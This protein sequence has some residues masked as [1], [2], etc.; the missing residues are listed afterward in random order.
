MA[1]REDLAANP[2]FA[3]GIV[4]FQHK[5]FTSFEQIQFRTTEANEAVAVLTMAG[6]EAVLGFDGIRR[7]FGLTP[8]TD[9][10]KML[11]VVEKGLKFVRGLKPGDPIPKEIL[12]GEASWT[13]SDRHLR[14]AHQRLTLQLVTWLTGDEHAFTSPEELLQVANDPQVKKNVTLAF[15]EAAE[16]LGIG[17]DRREEVV[18]YIEQLAKEFAYIEALRDVF[19]EIKKIDEKI[20]GLRRVYSSD[21]G[22]IETTDHVGRLSQR[23]ISI[24]SAY[25]YDIDAQTGEILSVLRNLDGQIEYIR[26]TRDELYCRM[27]PWDEFIKIWKTIYVVKSDENVM[28]LRDI[29]QFLAPRFMQVNEWVLVTKLG[30]DQSKKK[31]GTAMTW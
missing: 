22:M 31:Q 21:R 14:I 25:F 13:P 2:L 24:Y 27:F 10:G 19:N 7:E 30:F 28:R 16:A 6:N 4:R 9:D 8:D 18:Q 5:F 3:D 1:A 23:S 29:Y 17:R 15:S 26:K 12:S 11:D 20:Q